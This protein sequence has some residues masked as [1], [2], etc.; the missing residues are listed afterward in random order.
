MSEIRPFSPEHQQRAHISQPAQPRA[1]P[2]EPITFY[3][4]FKRDGLTAVPERATDYWRWITANRSVGEGK[5]S[6]TLQTYLQLLEAGIPCRLSEEFPTAGIV[7]SHRD[8]LPVF[9]LPRSDVFLVCIK[10]DRKEH[11]WAQHYIVQNQRD[12]VLALRK[13]RNRT[14]VIPFWPQPSLVP[15]SAS[16]GTHVEHAAYF[17]RLLNLTPELKDARWADTLRSLGFTWSTVPLEAW[18]DY[19]TI[20][21]T[22]SVRSFEETPAVVDPI[23]NADS[24]PPSKL[25]N[26][27]LAGVPAIVGRESA[28]QTIR[29]SDLDYIEVSSPDEIKDALIRLRDNPKLYA[30]MVAHGHKRTVD[31]STAATCRKWER[32]LYEDIAPSASAWR[33]RSS[34]GRTFTNVHG[35]VDYFAGLQHWKDLLTIARNRRR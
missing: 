31:Y 4:P 1:V 29:E 35:I 8:F 28:Y 11:T 34:L 12:A 26:S 30:A 10:P 18:N 13:G 15:R 33:S 22:V 6:W 21:V 14:S 32:A 19:S 20:D 23:T 24:K 9:M 5:Y 2:S 7:V 16:R 3:L 17:G 25:I 27:W